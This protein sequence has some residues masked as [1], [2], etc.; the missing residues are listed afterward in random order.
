LSVY[1]KPLWSVWDGVPFGCCSTAWT[2]SI[3]SEADTARFIA[4]EITRWEGLL[5]SAEPPPRR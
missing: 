5:R 2:A 1:I 3:T 4:A